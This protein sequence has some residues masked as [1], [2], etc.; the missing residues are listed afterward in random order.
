MSRGPLHPTTYLLR[1]AAKTIPLIAVILLAV[2]LVMGIVSMINS[3]PYSIR[4]IYSYSKNVLGV[5]PRGDPEMTPRIEKDIREQSPYPI[6][7]II[8]CRASG[9]QVKSI[10]G[11]WP[12][13]VLGMKRDDLEYFLN[14]L[15]AERVEGRLPESGKPEV[16][17]SE[18]VARN[19]GLR[20]GDN[21]LSPDTQEMYSPLPVKV[22]GI[23]QT[24]EWLMFND[25]T[26]Q[27]EN[28]FPPIENVLV[29]G[30]DLETQ[31][32]IDRWAYEE[33]RGERAQVLA[34]FQLEENTQEMFSILYR[35]LD[36]VIGTLVLV[37]TFMMGM[38]MNIYQSQRLVEFGLLQAIGYTKRQLIQRVFLETAIVIVSGWLLGVGSAL[39]LLNVVKRILMDPR[40]FALNTLDQVS[41]LYTVP[42]PIAIT[43]V[44]VL[45]VTRRFRKF[46]PVGVVERRLV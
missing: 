12:F 44:A 27:Q 45:T 36:V 10:V 35:I 14:K 25:I 37:I 21:L 33:F 23:A 41:I 1:N 24:T 4:T 40:A 9:A 26:Y 13:V 2:M 6:E 31:D 18:P 28:H 38:Q 42:I 16:V 11:K 34:Y 32:K 46:D 30:K 3:I 20:L 15:G 22:V 19:L 8:R 39:L 5:T 7:R 43:I 17:I 29:F